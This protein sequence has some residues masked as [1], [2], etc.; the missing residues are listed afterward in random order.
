LFI[1]FLKACKME[2]QEG[3]LWYL[4]D[5]QVYLDIEFWFN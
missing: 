1:D 5:L 4:H 2:I 3:L